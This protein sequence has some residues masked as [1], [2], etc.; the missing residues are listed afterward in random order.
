MG[1]NIPHL[2]RYFMDQMKY[3]ILQQTKSDGYIDIEEVTERL[4]S[5]VQDHQ[6]TLKTKPKDRVYTTKKQRVNNIYQNSFHDSSNDSDR[7]SCSLRNTNTP[8]DT[9]TK[10]AVEYKNQLDDIQKTIGSIY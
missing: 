8:Y 2:R 1:S 4:T 5:Y 7:S 10:K 9:P 6:E 3:G